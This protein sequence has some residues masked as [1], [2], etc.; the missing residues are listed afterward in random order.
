[1]EIHTFGGSMAADIRDAMTDG[2]TWDESP[3][4]TLTGTLGD[5]IR[6]IAALTHVSGDEYLAE[7]LGE[8]VVDEGP[9][10]DGRNVY[11]FADV[12]LEP[13]PADED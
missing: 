5:L 6:F 13:A 7:T 8:H 3:V 1:M 10:E 9:A 11:R 2:G 4:L 12:T